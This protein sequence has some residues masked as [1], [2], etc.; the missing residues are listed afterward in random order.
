[1]PNPLKVDGI[2]A[3]LQESEE[4]ERDEEPR[5]G[6]NARGHPDGD[7]PPDRRKGNS[8]HIRQS[9]PDSGLAFQVQVLKMF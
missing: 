9:R 2:G 4:D 7:P 8:A 6:Q 3:I 1:L 5:D